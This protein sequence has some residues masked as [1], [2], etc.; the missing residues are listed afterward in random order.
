MQGE[1]NTRNPK[2]NKKRKVTAE[3]TRKETIM[4]KN[5]GYE[6]NPIKKTITLS[7]KF[8][9]GASVMG[10]PEYKELKKIQKDN[11]DFEL[12]VREIQQKEDKITYSELTFKVM[13]SIIKGSANGDAEDEAQKIAEFNAIKAFYEGNKATM[14]GHV[15]SWFVQK[16]KEAYLEMYGNEN[17][18]KAA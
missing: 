9:K 14:Y 7:K 6:I 2:P 17:Q 12:V 10:T 15:K 13:E 4:K 8:L 11:P 3:Q 5:V 18:K 1:G 16:Y